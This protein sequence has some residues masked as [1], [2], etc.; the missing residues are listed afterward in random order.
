M[1]SRPRKWSTRVAGE[2][3]ISTPIGIARGAI[4]TSPETMKTD[5][6]KS[7]KAIVNTMTMMRH[8]IS[9]W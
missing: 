5:Y 4:E 3:S 2:K 1:A 9:P 7:K 8:G 6:A